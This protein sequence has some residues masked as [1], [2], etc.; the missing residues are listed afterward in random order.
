MPA[1]RAGRCRQVCVDVQEA[2]TRNVRGEIQLA[3]A[4]GIPELPAAVDE[5]VAQA[6]QLPPGDGGS[7]TD[8]GWITYTIPPVDVIHAFSNCARS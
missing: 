3:A 8:A 6:Y 2:R 7:G 4:A 1:T 5:L